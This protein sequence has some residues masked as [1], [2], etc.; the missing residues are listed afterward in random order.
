MEG[1]RGAANSGSWPCR[2]WLTRLSLSVP[3]PQLREDT[4]LHFA[5]TNGHVSM[6]KLLVERG[7]DVNVKSQWGQTP[8][9]YAAGE[10]HV[11][12]VKL[13]VEL[14]AEVGAKDFVV[15]RRMHR[16]RFTPAHALLLHRALALS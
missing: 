5:A 9:H 6:V 15:R 13:L 2:V 7:A 3:V 16:R 4:P 8:L 14:G 10:G 1:L 12:M 11:A